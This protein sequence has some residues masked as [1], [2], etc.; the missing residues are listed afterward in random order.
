MKFKRVAILGAG[1]LGGSLAL[2]LKAYTSSHVSLWGRR[3]DFFSWAEENDIDCFSTD[4]E[5]VVSEADL[6]VLATPVGFMAQ[7]VERCLPH[8]SREKAVVFSDVGSVKGCVSTEVNQVLEGSEYKNLT[9]I[10]SHPMAGSEQSGYLGSR[11]DLFQKRACIIDSVEGDD[12]L[13]VAADLQHFWECVGSEVIVMSPDDHDKAVAAISHFPHAVAS[14]ATEVSL[15]NITEAGCQIVGQGFLDTTRVAS[16]NAA[17]WGEIMLSNQEALVERLE[18]L[19][20]ETDALIGML[21]A[22]EHSK[23]VDW[24]QQAKDKRDQIS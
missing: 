19:K 8:V 22:N 16:G 6:I 23:L 14:L 11:A 17:M 15:D 12:R 10:G 9:F 20:R 18:A 13:A 1:L 3:K 2:A 21:N 4:L 7:L 24:L 5:A